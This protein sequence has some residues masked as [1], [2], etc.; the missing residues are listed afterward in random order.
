M[1]S[2]DFCFWLQGAFELS[3]PKTLDEEAVESIKAHLSLAFLHD[4]D[5]SM[6]DDKEQKKLEDAHDKS[7][8]T[9]PGGFIPNR[10]GG[11]T[12]RC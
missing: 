6:G 10:P 9:A 7:A 8:T 1:T 11:P 12:M 5:P 4:I 2:R 3:N